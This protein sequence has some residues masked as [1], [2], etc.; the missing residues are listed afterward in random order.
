MK[1]CLLIHGI[2]GIP[3][4]LFLIKKALEAKGF[5][6]R[7]ITLPGHDTSVEE[8]RKTFFNDWYAFAE[9]EF[10]AL[11]SRYESVAIVGFSLGSAITLKL[12]EQ[13]SP[14]AICPIAPPIYSLWQRAFA[15]KTQTTLKNLDKYILICYIILVTR[16]EINAEFD[17]AL[18]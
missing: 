10:L 18:V 3:D 17:S 9:K 4:E 7:T 12:A 2:G 8:F 5:H 11:Q 6:A 13:H 1:A 15:Q 14:K 16:F